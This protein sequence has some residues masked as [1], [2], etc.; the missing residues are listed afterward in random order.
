MFTAADHE[1]GFV[2][3]FV[4]KG[5]QERWHDLLNPKKRSKITSQL[6]HCKHLDPRYM[7]KIEGARSHP[8]EIEKWLKSKGAPSGCY[9]ISENS[10][11]DGEF[12][13]LTLALKATVGYGMGTVLSC[14]PGKLAYFEDEEIKSRFLL[15]RT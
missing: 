15:V 2:K 8:P 9:V 12:M 11:I 5:R 1:Q 14:I 6:A 7:V 10:R 3:S 13:S 4:V